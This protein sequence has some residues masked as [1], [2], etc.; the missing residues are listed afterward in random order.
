MKKLTVKKETLKKL[1]QGSMAK[2]NAGANATVPYREC[3]SI[4]KSLT[5][6]DCV[7]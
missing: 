7:S 1:S 4:L 5:K 3:M 2:V 6:V